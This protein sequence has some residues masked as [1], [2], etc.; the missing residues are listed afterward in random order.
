[1]NQNTNKLQSVEL[2]LDDKN[3]QFFVNLVLD[4][5]YNFNSNPRE[6]CAFDK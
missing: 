3:T 5:V 2:K 4:F 6:M 1:M